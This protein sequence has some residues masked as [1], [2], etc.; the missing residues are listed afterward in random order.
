[1]KDEYAMEISMPD[2]IRNMRRKAKRLGYHLVVRRIM[3]E[4]ET[5]DER[6]HQGM[7]LVDGLTKRA[8][9][10]GRFDLSSCEVA[11]FLNQMSVKH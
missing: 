4:N 1:M 5:S 9:L 10:D 3:F 2:T 7:M 8:V 6:N 11:T